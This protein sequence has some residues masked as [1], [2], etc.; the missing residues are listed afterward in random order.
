MR[1]FLKNLLFRQLKD[2]QYQNI[3]LVKHPFVLIFEFF[4]FFFLYFQ[5]ILIFLKLNFHVQFFSEF[6]LF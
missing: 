2:F 4:L 6:L 5:G 3:Y 1:K